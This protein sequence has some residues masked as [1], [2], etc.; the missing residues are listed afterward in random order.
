MAVNDQE[1]IFPLSLG[2]GEA[3]KHLF[4]PGDG[5]IIIRPS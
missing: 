3:I 2:L 5:Y 4:E 1:S